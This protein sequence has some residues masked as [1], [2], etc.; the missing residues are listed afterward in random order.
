MVGG[1]IVENGRDQIFYELVHSVNYKYVYMDG[2]SLIR[3]L[4]S[5]LIN[6]FICALFNNAVSIA[7]YT[8]LNE[9]YRHIHSCPIP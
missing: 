2:Y 8:V 6:L 9:T 1:V 5:V 3:I 4:I 7:G